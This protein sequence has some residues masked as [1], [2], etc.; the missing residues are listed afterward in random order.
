MERVLNV[1]RNMYKNAKSHVSVKNVLSDAFP[2][3]GGVR[4]GENLSPLP[5]AIYSS[6]FKTFLS[7]KYNGLH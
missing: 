3:Q 2:C 5:F 1:V 7:E 6:D 4:Q